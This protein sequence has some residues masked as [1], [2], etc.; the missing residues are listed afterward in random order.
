MIS[1]SPQLST[2]LVTASALGTTSLALPGPAM[3]GGS[4]GGAPGAGSQGLAGSPGGGIEGAFSGG[5]G[6]LSGSGTL[7]GDAISL[8]TGTAGPPPGAGNGVRVPQVIAQ[9][10]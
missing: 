5:L 1:S 4:A 6:G 8:D 7:S 2:L 3:G 9:F 10:N